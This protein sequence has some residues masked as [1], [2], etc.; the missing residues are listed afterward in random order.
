MT[1]APRSAT[2]RHTRWRWSS[3]RGPGSMT[4]ASVAPGSSRTQVLV[5]SRV[6]GPGLGASTQ[7]ARSVTCPPLHSMAPPCHGEGW[8]SRP[9]GKHPDRA[10]GRAPRRRAES[11]FAARPAPVDDDIVGRPLRHAGFVSDVASTLAQL[12]GFART[13]ALR[14]RHTKR[15]LRAAVANGQVVRLR[16]GRYAV[17]G[18]ER[19]P[20]LA[21]A[22]HGTL[23][24][25]SAA[26]QHGWKIKAV[27][28][29]AWVTIPRVRGQRSSVPEQV[30]LHHA[31]LA[32]DD[33]VFRRGARVTIPLRT[34]MDCARI[35]P[36]D[37]ALAVA[38]SAL[39]SGRSRL[40]NCGRRLPLP[41]GRG[42]HR[43]AGSPSSP[44]VARPTPSSRC[45]A[46]W[47]SRRAWPC[48]RR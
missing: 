1:R 41:R 35:L 9:G 43:C 20:G 48:N 38:D 18:F 47:P 7:N 17:P 34:V 27:P 32:D 40:P 15:A 30:H 29:K 45:S 12:G 28:E 31:D 3:S 19:D 2:T 33:V 46:P 5:P 13:R 23:S 4:T 14:R 39:R 6:I 8:A 37:D 26:L 21:L 25:L 10:M 16:H 24:H 11:P 44:M 36:F 42:R 22:C